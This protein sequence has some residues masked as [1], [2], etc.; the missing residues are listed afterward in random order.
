M[1]TTTRYGKFLMTSAAC[2]ALAGCGGADN[3]ASPGAGSVTIVQPAPTPTPTA[4]TPTPSAITAAQFAAVTT[5]N[6]I[7]ITADEQLAIVNAGSNNNINGT[8]AQMNGVYPVSSTSLTTATD[9]S[10]IN[11]LVSHG[12]T[13]TNA[14]AQTDKPSSPAIASRWGRTKL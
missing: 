6:G 13:S 14:E 12:C 9:P 4:P 7:S 2:L 10:S 8:G 1:A 3:V 11:S 5:V